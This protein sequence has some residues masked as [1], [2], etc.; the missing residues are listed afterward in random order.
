MYFEFR[1]KKSL[2]CC[3]EVIIW[4][5]RNQN[6]K[7][8]NIW[9]EGQYS[10]KKYVRKHSTTMAAITPTTTTRDNRAVRMINNSGLLVVVVV[11]VVV[12]VSV[13]TLENVE[14]EFVGLR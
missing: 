12:L 5:G 11:V 7:N 6:F 9:I 2:F 8:F 10:F 3:S 13:E 4:S 14:G 1:N